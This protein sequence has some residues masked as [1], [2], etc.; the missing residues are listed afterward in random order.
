MNFKF[1]NILSFILLSFGLIFFSC[2]KEEINRPYLARVGNSILTYQEV[3]S[4]LGGDFDKSNPRF[5]VYVQ[6]WIETEILYQEAMKKGMS[7]NAEVEKQLLEIRRQL[8]VQHLITHEIYS[9]SSELPESELKSYFENHPEEFI[10]RDDAVLLNYGSFNDRQVA[11]DF[12][13]DILKDKSWT[14]ATSNLREDVQKGESIT[15]IVSDN[16][17]TQSTLFPVELW[18]IVQN[19]SGNDISFPIKVGENYFVVQV[20][21]KYLKGTQADYKTVRSEVKVKALIAK[22]R[23]KYDTYLSDLRKHYKVEL[24]IQ[25]EAKE[26]E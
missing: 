5:L 22:R 26:V 15:S 14:E 2:K 10:F 21:E 7:T 16:M 6:K 9:D 20:L 18:K 23:I 13:A 25:E 3:E 19:L 12:R 24:K 17:F 11:N 4:V 1:L 8:A